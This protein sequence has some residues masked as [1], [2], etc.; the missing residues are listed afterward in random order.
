MT[1]SKVGLSFVACTWQVLR[2][3]VAS[4]W[5]RV[6]KLCTGNPS[7]VCFRCFLI[8]TQQRVSGRYRIP[9][10]A[11]LRQIFFLKQQRRQG[12]SH[13]PFHVVGH[14]AEENMRTH[15]LLGTQIDRQYR[16]SIPFQHRN[17]R[18]TLVRFL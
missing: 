10:L 17:A 7:T 6:G 15:M 18:S 13:M 4:A 14:Q 16:I 5:S 2:Q 12:R 8:C 11:N 3:R 9:L 1:C